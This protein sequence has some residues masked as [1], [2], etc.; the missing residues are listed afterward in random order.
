MADQGADSSANALRIS[1]IKN[2]SIT[3]HTIK[4]IYI[5]LPFINGFSV[6]CDFLKLIKKSVNSINN[7]KIR[8]SIEKAYT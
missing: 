4:M 6:N 8:K 5:L 7:A 3:E 1:L 2:S